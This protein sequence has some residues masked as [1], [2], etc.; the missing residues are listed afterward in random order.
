MRG[1]GGKISIG[2]AYRNRP[3]NSIF[4]TAKLKI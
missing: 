2:F 3:P 4:T 1:G